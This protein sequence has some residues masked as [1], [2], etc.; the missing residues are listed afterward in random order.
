MKRVKNIYAF[1]TLP[2]RKTEHDTG[3]HT[4]KGTS[5]QKILPDVRIPHLSQSFHSSVLPSNLLHSKSASAPGSTHQLCRMALNSL[6]NLLHSTTQTSCN[7][8]V[9]VPNESNV[10]TV[11]SW[12]ASQTRSNTKYKTTSELYTTLY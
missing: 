9:I 6:A 11:P 10:P 5:I 1:K 2:A 4:N 12:S 7:A 3:F 8:E